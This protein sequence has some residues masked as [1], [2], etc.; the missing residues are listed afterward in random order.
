M[1]TATK[2]NGPAATLSLD[3]LQRTKIL[4]LGQRGS[5]SPLNPRIL[6][7]I[8]TLRRAEAERLPS[9]RSFST[10]RLR[11]RPSFSN[12]HPKPLY[13][14]MSMSNFPLPHFPVSLLTSLQCTSTVIPLEIWDCPGNITLDSLGASLSEFSSIIFVIDIQVSC[15]SFIRTASLSTSCSYLPSR[16]PISN[17]LH[18]C[19]NSSFRH[20]KRIQVQH[21]RCSRTKQSRSQRTTR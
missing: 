15:L 16:I 14:D 18:A 19:S 13:I 2:S 4:L 20:I 11:S 7:P 6:F 21:W 5:V 3:N 8:S 10:M 12:P 9:S 17:P 1:A